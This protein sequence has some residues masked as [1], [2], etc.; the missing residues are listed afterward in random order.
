MPRIILWGDDGYSRD[1]SEKHLGSEYGLSHNK[2][3]A[4][5]APSLQD[6]RPD[7]FS[8]PQQL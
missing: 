7:A 4:V 3:G 1:E 5:T 6:A 2:M 8:M